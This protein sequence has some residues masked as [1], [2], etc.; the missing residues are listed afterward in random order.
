MA[1][2]GK[3]TF[4]EDE[5]KGCGLCAEACPK[6][7]IVMLPDRL[8]KKGFHPAGVADDKRDFCIACAFCGIMCPDTVIKVEK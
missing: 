2:T 5:C 4:K 6:K 1:A 7:I 8:N 3:V